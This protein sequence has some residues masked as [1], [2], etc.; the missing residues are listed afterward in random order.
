ML[1]VLSAF[2]RTNIDPWQ[3][4]AN[5]SRMSREVATARMVEFICALPDNPNALIPA[6]T[7]A[8]DLIALLPQTKT[9]LRGMAGKSSEV[10]TTADPRLGLGFHGD[11]CRHRD[12]ISV[13][14]Q[15]RS[16]I[17]A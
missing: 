11:R 16:P 2:A 8:S 10:S 3:E 7:V 13:L 5:L 4:A 12:P 1:T 14:E 9:S 17:R 6:K 15:S